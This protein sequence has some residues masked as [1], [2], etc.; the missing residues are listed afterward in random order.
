MSKRPRKSCDPAREPHL[1]ENSLL[2]SDPRQTLS[3]EQLTGFRLEM[4]RTQAMQMKKKR[5]V[6]LV[7]DEPQ[8]CRLMER[9]LAGSFDEVIVA[10]NA[11]DA[12]ELL[13][14]KRVTHILSDLF[15][16]TPGNSFA[17]I[18]LWRVLFQS[19]ER[20]VIFTA[21]D[22]QGVKAAQE[23][24]FP[25]TADAVDA[26][27]SKMDGVDAVIEALLGETR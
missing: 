2:D 12:F 20:C 14:Q 9:C 17:S 19:I 25:H 16:E 4:R 5:T 11:L 21:A 23:K 7:D 18:C 3:A 22:V 24:M 15:F 8:I 13:K 27:L 1:K 10:H 6:L 26:V